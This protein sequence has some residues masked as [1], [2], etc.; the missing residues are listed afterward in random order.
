MPF[1]SAF[2]YYSIHVR[3]FIRAGL[4]KGEVV[5]QWPVSLLTGEGNGGERK[6]RPIKKCSTL[7][8]LAWF[9]AIFLEINPVFRLSSDENEFYEKF[10]FP[11]YN[12][13]YKKKKL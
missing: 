4:Q 7:G 11:G 8:K 1:A 3:I 9:K 2:G 6:I 10:S 5:K 12:G 13:M